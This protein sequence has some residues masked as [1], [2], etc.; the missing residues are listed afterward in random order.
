MIEL[1]TKPGDGIALHVPCYPPFLASIQRSGR[2]VVPIEWRDT[3]NGWE[4]DTGDLAGRLERAGVTMLVVVNPHNPTG[5][6]LSRLELSTLAKVARELDLTV[7][8]DEIHSDLIYDGHQH[9]PFASL[10]QDAAD[11]TVTATSA[12]KAF[13]IASFHCSVAHVGPERLWNALTRAPTNLYGSPSGLSIVA[14]TAAWTES[15]EW[16]AEVMAV[17]SANRDTIAQWAAR[18]GLTHH[19]PEATYLAWLGFGGTRAA[20]GEAAEYLENRAKVMLNP[21]SHFSR[22]TGLDTRSW[23]RINFATTEGTLLEILDRIE[24]SL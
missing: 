3:G 8:S 5:R 20:R 22:G 11:R 13:N 9:V 2:S 23:A 14:H 12:S 16:L 1:A 21:G 4:A 24:R 10:D 17:L 19:A 6:V 15:E 18:L 7:L